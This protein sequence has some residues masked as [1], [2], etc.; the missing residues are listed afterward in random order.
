M[1]RRNFLISGLAL[2]ALSGCVADRPAV[3]HAASAR[4]VPSTWAGVKAEFGLAPDLAHMSG[5]FLASHPRVVREALE[6]HRRG[7]DANP[8][9]YL[10]KQCLTLEPAVRAAASGY[11]GVRPDDL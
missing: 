10:E 6:L 7:L 9:E 1:E 11:F 8:L 3:L 4:G 2:G 5:F